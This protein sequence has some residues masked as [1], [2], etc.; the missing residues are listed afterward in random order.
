VE[1][2]RFA[3]LGEKIVAQ[4]DKDDFN[5]EDFQY[6][7][8][9]LTPLPD[10][11]QDAPAAD[12]LAPTQA[13]PAAD[14]SASVSEAA[15]PLEPADKKSKKKAKKEKPAKVKKVKVAA[16]ASGEEKEQ[17]AFLQQLSKASPY[18]VLLGMTVVALLLT[19]IYLFVEL[20]HY[21]FNTKAIMMNKS[22]TAPSDGSGMAEIEN[23][24]SRLSD[25]A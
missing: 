6:S 11:N 1:I 12:P 14:A 3:G 5:L 15:S 9:K 4:P 19:V 25:F 21:D 16:E 2:R 8:V 13:S 24:P 22:I 7:G 23:G 18:T 20:S 17:S 10:F